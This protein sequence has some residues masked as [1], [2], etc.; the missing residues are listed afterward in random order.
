MW[1][2]SFVV[3]DR[4]PASPPSAQG[5]APQ[6]ADG[7]R[8]VC[9][10]GSEPSPGKEGRM[11]PVCRRVLAFLAAELFDRDFNVDYN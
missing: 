10:D 9:A 3:E 6:C 4:R 11:T 8:P 7:T 2:L 5:A 1:F